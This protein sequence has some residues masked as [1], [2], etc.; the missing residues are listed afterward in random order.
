MP[1]GPY[2][3]P[4]FGAPFSNSLSSAFP[5]PQSVGNHPSGTNNHQGPVILGNRRFRK[6]T[7]SSERVCT[8][9]VKCTI[10]NWRIP[11]QI[12]DCRCSKLDFI[13]WIDGF[14]DSIDGVATTRT[15]KSL[16]VTP[17]VIINSSLQSSSTTMLQKVAALNHDK[18]SPGLG[19]YSLEVYSLGVR[20][21]DPDPAKHSL[22]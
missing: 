20:D 16:D 19:V 4:R 8:L 11:H 10:R 6:P 1:V 18:H 14:I 13:D 3:G 17:V 2:Q 22:V 9:R 5:F 21:L 12:S 7:L 15:C